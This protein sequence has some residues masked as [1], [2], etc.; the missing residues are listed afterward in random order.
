LST[1]GTKKYKAKD[2]GL[3]IN[4][5]LTCGFFAFRL[6][7]FAFGLICSRFFV[8]FVETTPVNHI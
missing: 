1:K 4:Y 5:M 8:L 3:K 7:P 6:S 2:E